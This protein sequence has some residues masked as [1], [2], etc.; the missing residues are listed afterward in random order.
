MSF[1][2]RKTRYTWRT[3]LIDPLFKSTLFSLIFL[4]RIFLIK[5][6]ARSKI[7][8]LPL[9]NTSLERL[10]DTL[11][12][13]NYACNLENSYL[14]S[15]SPLTIYSFNNS[16]FLFLFL[17]Q[18]LVQLSKKKTRRTCVESTLHTCLPPSSLSESLM[19][20]RGKYRV[21]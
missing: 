21:L 7:N 12:L 8:R 14:G 2:S 15:I 13:K 5:L 11:I 6:L 4:L 3:F 16:A 19:S 9:R 10:L 17:P 20:L 1:N 18:P